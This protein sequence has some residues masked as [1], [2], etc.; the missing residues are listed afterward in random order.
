MNRQPPQSPAGPAK[1][2]R[3]NN[4][5]VFVL[6][7]IL[8]FLWMCYHVYFDYFVK[9]KGNSR[10]WEFYIYAVI[11]VLGI[12]LVRWLLRSVRIPTWLLILAQISI[13]LHFAG[14][15]A[16]W[17]QDRLY[18]AVIG[19]I[20]FDKY[21]HFYNVFVV[22]WFFRM[23]MQ[24]LK[25]TSRIV[26]EILIVLCALGLGAVSEIIEYLVTFAVETNG[27]GHYHNNMQDLIANGLGALFNVLVFNIY[28]AWVPTRVTDRMAYDEHRN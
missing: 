3:I 24:D 19:G 4:K 26:D 7:N 27:V 25:T 10:N 20:R 1:T 12:L 2:D 9:Y 5:D 6:V 18:N 14:G 23:I 8:L 28:C 22:V 16:I 17:Q 11:I 13:L 21:V 15:M